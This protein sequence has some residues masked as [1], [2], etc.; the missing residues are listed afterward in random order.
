MSTFGRFPARL[1]HAI[2]DR[3]GWTS[4]R[5]VQELAGDALLD[6]A[7]AVV[8]APTAGGKTEAAMFP[9]LAELIAHP[10]R[11]VGILYIAPIKA[12][13]NNQA[14]RLDLYTEMVG[15]R[16]F[17]WHGDVDAPERRR[18]VR[19]P[20]ELLMTTP[21][22]IEVMFVSSSV[23]VQQV[24]GD[25]RMVIVDE[26]HALAGQERGAHLMSVVERLA[27]VSRHDIQRVGLSATVGNPERILSW[28]AGSSSRPGRVI[29][30]PKVPARRNLLVL[31]RPSLPEF[32][33]D[34]ANVA[35]VGKSLF[36]CQ[37]RATSEAV[38]E[39][40]RKQSVRVYVHHSAVSRE[41]RELAEEQFHRGENAC[42]VCT[43]TL[44][45]GIDVGDL[46]KVLQAEAPDSVGSFLQRM[47]RTGRR[48][49]QTANTTFLCETD[50]S[51]V[52]AVALVELAR[53]GWVESVGL[54]DRCWPVLAQQLFAMA[55]A[56]GGI[57]PEHAWG[58]LRRVPD[59]A[60]IAREEFDALLEHMLATEAMREAAGRLVL[61]PFAEQRLGRRNFMEVFAVFSSP[62]S[63]T[64]QTTAGQPLG[65]LGQAFVDRLVDGAST[66]LLGGRA[67]AVLRIQ[68]DDRR[69]LV[70][71]A[72]RGRKPTWGGS[73]PIF[74][75]QPLT[76]K[77]GEILRSRA[78]YAY[79]DEA[80]TAA[81]ATLRA[82]L[83]DATEA[84]AP[85]LEERPGEVRW[86]TFAGGR[87]NATLRHALETVGGSWR[88]VP[89][90]LAVDIR[91]PSLTVGVVA[92]AIDRLVHHELWED[93]AFWRDVVGQMP[94][95]RLSK[96]QPFLP[97]HVVREVFEQTL[98]DADG[99]YRWLRVHLESSA[100]ADDRL[101]ADGRSA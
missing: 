14:E 53:G 10:P 46:D 60:G 44:E 101:P 34:A 87:I 71:G 69:I 96:F 31:H 25:L 40:M 80:A 41:E 20:V 12:L 85:W 62:Q 17:V 91:A 79:L 75:S 92:T 45:L 76:E 3:L 5:P 8:L 22:S 48:A 82:E 99:A 24:F 68:H 84:A 95:Y 94:N 43:S 74:L 15:M 6:G 97:P 98:L 28:L 93:E 36:F 73:L 26:V 65:T 2:V 42:I 27:S 7:N 67:W 77:M 70:E 39:Q 38:A 47:G 90:N 9:A 57:T 56:D 29:D 32:C 59:F 37:S 52:Q 100:T 86:W 30:P 50:E 58:Q 61:G 51:V 49:G 55:L 66:F 19:E 18:F 23:D 64:V 83:A 88:V 16:R 89:G 33:L 11:G 81:L 13:L 35:R 21:E 63:Y 1:Q 72:P 4:L 54:N 78:D